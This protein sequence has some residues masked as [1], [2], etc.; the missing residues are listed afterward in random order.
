M[1]EKKAQEIVNEVT[2]MSLLSTSINFTAC[3]Y[4]V[5]LRK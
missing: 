4:I 5:D 1:K 2:L 3:V